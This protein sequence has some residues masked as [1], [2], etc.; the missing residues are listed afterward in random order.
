[1]FDFFEKKKLKSISTVTGTF[2]QPAIHRACDSP[3][4]GQEGGEV[5][6]EPGPSG[7]NRRRNTDIAAGSSSAASS[8]THYQKHH[9]QQQQSSNIEPLEKEFAGQ[10]LSASMGEIL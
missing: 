2:S 6:D 1:M 10:R 7:Y 9:Q 3:I 8:S 4:P 5:E